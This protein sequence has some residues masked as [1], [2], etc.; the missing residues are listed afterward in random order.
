VGAFLVRGGREIMIDAVPGVDA[1]TL[2]LSLLGPALALVLHQRGRFVLHA[3][4]VAVAGS[5]IAFLGEK[6]WGKSTIAAALYLALEAVELTAGDEVIMPTMTFAAT[7]EVVLYF[8]A[9]P[10]LV[11]CRRDTLHLDPEQIEKAMT[12]RTK[13]LIPVHFG[14]SPAR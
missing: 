5:A 13:A 2:R 14:V 9:R 1:R 4:T 12:S 6:G 10:V 11:D 3:S 8:R 7:A